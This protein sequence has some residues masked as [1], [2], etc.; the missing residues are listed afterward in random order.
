MTNT[1]G[2]VL[3]VITTFMSVAFLGFAFASKIAGPNW[4]AQATA[5]QNYVVEKT[6]TEKET[7]Y[8]VKRKSAGKEGEAEFTKTSKL[9][10]DV[11][12]AAQNDELKELETK[13]AAL[14]PQLAPLE[15]RLKEVTAHQIVD[16]KAMEQREQELTADFQKIAKQIQ[17]LSVE[18]DKVAQEALTIW[19]EEELRREDGY[20]YRNQ[21]EELEVD[22]FQ[23][24]EQKKRLQ[25]ELSRL[26]GV[27]ARLQRRHDQ[28]ETR[29]SYEK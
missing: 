6:V 3:A 13:T 14:Q 2:K 25:D 12:L 7:T 27:L 11:I 26:R 28:L 17:E 24:L 20:R 9:L 10:P 16:R 19:A 15:T 8:T 18:G 22:R 29:A 5:L 21:L 1:I 23:L 4:E